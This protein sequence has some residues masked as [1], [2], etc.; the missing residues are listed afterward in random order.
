M[1]A[2]SDFYTGAFPAEYSDALAAVFDMKL[3]TGNPDKHE[4]AMQVGLLGVDVASEGPF[5]QKSNASY[6]FNY[7]YSTFGLL[8]DLKI[9]DTEQLFKYQDLSFKINIPT[10]CF[11]LFALGNGGIDR[12]TQGVEEDPDNWVVDFDKLHLGG[13]Q[14]SELRFNP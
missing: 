12:A 14:G 9:L 10:A 3:R 8:A 2:N 6:L 5:S 13:T 1:M 11:C 7:R 4:H